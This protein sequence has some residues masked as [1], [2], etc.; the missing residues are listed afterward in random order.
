[1]SHVRA[2]L[3]C[4]GP[5]SIEFDKLENR[6]PV[7]RR[8]STERALNVQ[9]LARRCGLRSRLLFFASTISIHSSR[10][11]A[12][13]VV[14]LH[15]SFALGKVAQ[16]GQG[17]VQCMRLLCHLRAPELHSHDLHQTGALDWASAGALDRA[18]QEPVGTPHGERR[19][20]LACHPGVGGASR[21]RAAL[22]QR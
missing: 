9:P 1:M 8:T 21:R 11:V 13:A 17:I 14:F 12:A 20:L 5:R 15:C 10:S 16:D 19:R 6:N 3:A 4:F 7:F 18:Q 2:R 22:R